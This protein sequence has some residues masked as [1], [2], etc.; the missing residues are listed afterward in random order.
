MTLAAPELLLSTVLHIIAPTLDSTAYCTA[1]HSSYEA[2][3]AS[4]LV[5][6]KVDRFVPER[7]ARN[8]SSS[9]LLVCNG[10]E[11]VSNGNETVSLN[12]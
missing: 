5:S 2:Y 1:Y 12:C 7:G 11:T 8:A 6:S 3:L 4:T 10:N 9:K